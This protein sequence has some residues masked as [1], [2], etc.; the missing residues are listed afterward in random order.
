MRPGGRRVTGDGGQV[1][2]IETIAL[3]LLTFVVG[4]LLAANAW[5][6]VDAR[7]AVS[8]AAREATRAYV[9]APDAATA[10]GQADEVARR[11][12]AARGRHADRADVT[13]TAT[14]WQRCARVVVTV[15]VPVPLLTLPYVG[16]YGRAFDATGTHSE[17]IDPYRAGLPAGGRC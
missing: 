7:M 11:S 1:A 3:G 10:T 15:R 8:A 5:A 6:V 9:E 16:G 14:A 4:G 17:L 12:L 2:G 13:V